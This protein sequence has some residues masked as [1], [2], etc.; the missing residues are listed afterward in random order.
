VNTTIQALKDSEARINARLDAIET[1]RSI[2]GSGS[3]T[4]RSL[5]GGSDEQR[6]L[7]TFHCRNLPELLQVNSCAG[8]FRHVNEGDKA[9]VLELKKTF[10]IARWTRQMFHGEARDPEFKDDVAQ[11]PAVRGILDSRFAKDVRLK[12]L[13]RAFSSTGAGDGDEWVPTI[14]SSTYV[15][16]YELE[17]KLAALIKELPAP[18]SPWDLSVQTDK[19]RARLIAENTNMTDVNFGTDKITF[20][21]R[22]LGE[23]FI[24][25]EELNEDSAPAILELGRAEIV[26][27][28]IRAIEDALVNGDTTGTHMDSDVTAASDN[29][30]AW[31]GLRK[32][33]LAA[34]STIDFAG[35]AMTDPLTRDMRKLAGKYGINPKQCGWVVG[36]AAYQQMQALDAFSTLEKFGPQ[37]TNISGA[38]GMAYG[39]PV[40]VSEF[41]RE[42]L[43]DS[44]VYDGVTTNRTVAH[45]ANLTRFYIARRRPIKIRVVQDP[46]VEADRWKLASYQ[47]LDFKG[48]KQAGTAY[49]SGST[50]T[51]RSSIL[52][53]D[54]LA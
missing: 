44:G 11:G 23:Y 46:N 48:H 17:R 26:S 2:V 15:E 20:T 12:E 9:A 42:D 51:E 50:S 49:A 24:I 5:G 3:N 37:A 53:I 10:D 34:S 39:I 33:A 27:S 40:I 29:R 28:Q 25:P 13:C 8:K 6:L 18:S 21:A 30:K 43:N 16:E 41:V 1:A 7:R 31:M 22:K 14:V 38:L 47:R 35:A 45:F 19:T 4:A 52:G 36:P 54:I 32:L